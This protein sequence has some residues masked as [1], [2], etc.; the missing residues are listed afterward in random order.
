MNNKFVFLVSENK[1]VIIIVVVQNDPKVTSRN[2]TVVPIDTM[3]AY[4]GSTG[5][6]PPW[7]KMQVS[8]QLYTLA[9]LNPGDCVGLSASPDI[10]EKRT[11]FCP[12]WDLNP[13][14][15]GP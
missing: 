15:S 5:I 12:C 2:G 14:L 11:T 10:L 7:H 6:A 9:A 1:N 13:A 3:K 4:R 8:G